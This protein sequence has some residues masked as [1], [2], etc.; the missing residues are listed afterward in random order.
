MSALGQKRT[1]CDAGAMSALPPNSGHV[2]CSSACPLS[3]NSGHAQTAPS[4]K[5]RP[6][7]GG[8]RKIKS[9]VYRGSNPLAVKACLTVGDVRNAISA[10]AAST[11]LLSALIPATYKE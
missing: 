1:F 7:R 3:A 11:C 9:G 8:P 10:L 2:Q 4:E 6:P 5:E